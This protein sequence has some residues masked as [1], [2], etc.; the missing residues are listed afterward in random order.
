MFIA[1][2]ADVR[3]LILCVAA[4]A[5]MW[6]PVPEGARWNFIPDWTF[7]GGDLKKDWTV[8]GQA[9]WK[10]VDGEVIGTPTS[11]EGG[12]L[13][14]NKGLQDF[15]FGA[16]LKCAAACKAGVLVRARKQ[17]DGSLSGVFIPYGESETGLFTVTIDPSGRE[18]ARTPL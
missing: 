14:L 3:R 17:A 16:D 12:W 5:I 6:V 11:P 18:T 1:V 4:I 2:E 13:V 15:Q 9:T 8:I 10:A 7:K